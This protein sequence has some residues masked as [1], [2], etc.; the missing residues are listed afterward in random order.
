M[1]D[2]GSRK[3]VVVRV[4]RLSLALLQAAGRPRRSEEWV[5]ARLLQLGDLGV[6]GEVSSLEDG[7]NVGIERLGSSLW[8]A[9]AVI[10][11]P[12]RRERLLALWQLAEALAVVAEPE[13]ELQVLGRQ[14]NVLEEVHE[15]AHGAGLAEGS[16]IKM[17]ADTKE[18][19][20]YRAHATRN[21]A[22]EGEG[23]RNPMGHTAAARMD[24]IMDRLLLGLARD[25]R[26]G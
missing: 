21:D 19:L 8:L 24:R 15:V 1:V 18:Q 7:C 13:V 2:F 11:N 22:V 26:R 9:V 20:T 23:F 12:E 4:E 25:G 10:A 16:A 14:F 3:A 17:T 6:I 5:A